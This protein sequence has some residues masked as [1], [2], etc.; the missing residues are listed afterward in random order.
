MPEII[1]SPVHEWFSLSYSNYLVLPRSLMQA[2][3]VEWQDRMVACLEEMCKACEPLQPM[4][5]KYSVILH[6]ERGRIVK[7]PYADYRHP[8]VQRLGQ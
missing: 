6:G 4:N 2:M 5:D 1:D 7:D 3:P 8:E